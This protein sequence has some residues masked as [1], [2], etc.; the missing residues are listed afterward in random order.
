V[1][2]AMQYNILWNDSQQ[3]GDSALSSENEIVTEGSLH[4]HFD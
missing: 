4:K 3:S 2:N 1:E